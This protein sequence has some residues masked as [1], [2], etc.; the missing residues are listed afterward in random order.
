LNEKEIELDLKTEKLYQ[1]EK[2][3]EEY[4][5][6]EENLNAT[7]TSLLSAVSTTVNDIQE[8]HNKIGIF[9]FLK[10][11]LIIYLQE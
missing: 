4:K 7:A 6:T 2:I 10:K 8:L 5:I 1:Q 11:K 3:T 9:L